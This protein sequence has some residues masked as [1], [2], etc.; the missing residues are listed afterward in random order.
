MTHVGYSLGAN[1][2]L[3]TRDHHYVVDRKLLS[4]HAEDRDVTKWPKANQFEIILPEPLLNVQSLR[5]IQATFPGQFYTFSADNQNTQLLYTFIGT[6]VP[7]KATI[8][9]GYY[10][11]P[12]LA[13][14]LTR[15][16]NSVNVYDASFAV[17]YDQA[18]EKYW[19]GHP[20]RPFI[21]DFNLPVAY[22]GD[23]P[24]RPLLWP[25]SVNWGLPFHLG[26]QKSQYK[27]IFMASG[28]SIA[29]PESDPTAPDP[30]LLQH[31]VEAPMSLQI[32]G[33]TCMYMEV[34]KYNSLDEM[35]P[36]N[37]SSRGTFDN[38]A[39]NGKVNAAFAKI[40]IY[41][42][43]SGQPILDSR[44]FYLQNTV[45]YEPPIERIARLKFKLRFHDGRLV[46]FQNASFDFSLEFILLRNEI[47][48]QSRQMRLPANYIL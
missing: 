22:G 2:P 14:E 36:Y 9:E 13:R 34:E 11:P 43:Q 33:D 48:S 30:T 26:F 37:Q 38:N 25:Q 15:A 41:R 17:V 6:F 16:L 20:T 39:Y 1:K 31:F 24:E 45:Q 47:T 23:C 46:N 4:V 7:A 42:T 8:L 19:I 40:P 28:I 27:S 21:L 12:Q 18:R 3:I 10:T 44:T 5:L 32:A 35:Y 29:V